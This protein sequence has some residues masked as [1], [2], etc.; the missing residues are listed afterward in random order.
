M[1]A[2]RQMASTTGSTRSSLTAISSR[3]FLNR[4]MSTSTPRYVSLNPTSRLE[5][6]AFETVIPRT[7]MS[8][9]AFLTS[10]NFCGSM[11]AMIIFIAYQ[12]LHPVAMIGKRTHQRPSGTKNPFRDDAPT[13]FGVSRQG[14]G[15]DVDRILKGQTSVIPRASLVST[16]ACMATFHVLSEAPEHDPVLDARR[17]DGALG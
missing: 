10:G 16:A 11:S 13:G 12:L 17:V 8:K 3:T 1:R 6:I 14:A 4:Y 7:S 9:S 15:A 5:P 2:E